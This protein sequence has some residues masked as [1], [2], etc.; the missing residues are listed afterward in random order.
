MV[1]EQLVGQVSVFSEEIQSDKQA[2]H[3]LTT[4][5]AALVNTNARLENKLN[6]ALTQITSMQTEIESLKQQKRGGTGTTAMP[7]YYC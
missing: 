2:I 7:A 3:N 1:T 5:K 6:Q 4:V